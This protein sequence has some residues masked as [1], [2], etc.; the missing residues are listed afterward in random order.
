V[1]D[2]KYC[3]LPGPSKISDTFGRIN[4]GFGLVQQDVEANETDIE[5]HKASTSAHRAA[6]IT[7]N[8]RVIATNVEEAI[9]KQDQRIDNI[10]AQS[11]T[12]N[13]EVVD[14]RHDNVNN[15]TYPVLG[16]RLDEQS[17][18]INEISIKNKYF[19]IEPPEQ[20][21]LS[22][23]YGSNPTYTTV[24]NFYETLRSNNPDYIAV[25]TIGKD[26]SNTY[27]V[28]RYTFTPKNY[29]KTCYIDAGIH[30]D[31][32]T[33]VFALCNIMEMIT[34]AYDAK[35]PYFAEVREGV[36]FVVIPV[37][38][39]WGFQAGSRLNVNEVDINRNFSFRW[40]E[41]VPTSSI[42]YKGTNY[43][44][45][46]ESQYIR[47]TLLQYNPDFYFNLHNTNSHNFDYYCDADYINSNSNLML[48]LINVF[49]EKRKVENPDLEVKGVST[50][51]D[52][53]IPSA[54]GYASRIAGI[55]SYNL[56][57]CDTSYG[58]QYSSIEMTKCVEWFFSMIYY[59]YKETA[60]APKVQSM[61]ESG[62][63]DFL[64]GTVDGL[65]AHMDALKS[66]F[67]SNKLE[68]IKLNFG[69][70]AS[71]THDIP[72]YRFTPLNTSARKKVLLLGGANGLYWESNLSLV[73]MVERYLKMDGYLSNNVVMYVVPFL[74]MW[75]AKQSPKTRYNAN[76]VLLPTNFGYNWVAGENAGSAPFS[77]IETQYIRDLVINEQIDVL[78]DFAGYKESL[79]RLPVEKPIHMQETRSRFDEVSEP[80]VLDVALINTCDVAT[81]ANSQGVLSY[82]VFASSYRY[83]IVQ[84]SPH[85]TK[86]SEH[87]ATLLKGMLSRVYGRVTLVSHM[88]NG[89]QFYEGVSNQE[90]L[91]YSMEIKAPCDGTVIFNGAIIL[92]NE[93]A[94]NIVY[95]APILTTGTT[96]DVSYFKNLGENYTD[97]TGR[98]IL[99]Q[100]AAFPVRKGDTV[101]LKFIIS[102]VGKVTLYRLRGILE[103]Q[104]SA[105]YR[106][107]LTVI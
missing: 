86:I 56:E 26:T 96:Y 102:T 53:T 57:W 23:K 45:E 75:G 2:N 62:G 99:P 17:E 15:V 78:L 25:E 70:D 18:K 95:T 38:N 73:A 14:S 74:D 104:E 61:Q 82:K 72:Y 41:F 29:S 19:V 35:H 69:K 37:V 58:T 34:D 107:S 100:Y 106:T 31:E 46:K 3:N 79:R 97:V 63:F 64:N 50:V 51:T 83:S 54:V 55:Q 1:A 89:S 30:G 84:L 8:G 21:S 36:R 60:F 67:E 103:F 65:I 80:D 11:G 4:D 105:T 13:T 59:N 76:N 43:F 10:V 92:N 52:I 98:V 48:S 39:P 77:E 12:D 94:A 7:Y 49:S 93:V 88:T 6:A 90:I 66:R 91:P 101:R 20:Q 22:E 27:D 16:D 28:Y 44:S 71:G 68:I 33:N 32:R 81:W 87:I 40:N 47:D 85:L 24:I 9:D 5:N 42:D